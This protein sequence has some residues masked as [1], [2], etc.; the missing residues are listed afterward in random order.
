MQ[1]YSSD[2]EEAFVEEFLLFA[3]LYKDKKTVTE[4]KI[5]QIYDKLVTSFPN[6][7]IA[8]RIY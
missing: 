8:F 6:V 7:N 2:L 3:R 5:A 4:M 1:I